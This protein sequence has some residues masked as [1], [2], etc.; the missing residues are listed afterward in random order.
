MDKSYNPPKLVPLSGSSPIEY[1]TERAVAPPHAPPPALGSQSVLQSCGNTGICAPTYSSQPKIVRQSQAGGPVRSRPV[2]R[3]SIC[4]GTGVC[5]KDRRQLFG[6]ATQSLML[7]GVCGWV[8]MS[9]SCCVV[10]R[11]RVIQCSCL[12]WWV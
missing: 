4:V 7:H 1:Q 2:S 6:D 8:C 11:C 5:V 3:L 10:R 9:K 12:R